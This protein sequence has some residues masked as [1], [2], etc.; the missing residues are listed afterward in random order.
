LRHDTAGL[1]LDF[2]AVLRPF[3]RESSS[4]DLAASE[5]RGVVWS[6]LEIGAAVRRRASLENDMMVGDVCALLL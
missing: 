5:R 1:S 6:V 2:M 4:A 3:R